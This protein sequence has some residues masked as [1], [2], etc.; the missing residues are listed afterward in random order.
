MELGKHNGSICSRSKFL[1]A[2]FARMTPD[3]LSDFSTTKD[4]RWML[5][6]GERELVFRDKGAGSSKLSL[7]ELLFL[8]IRF[9]ARP[10]SRGQKVTQAHYENS[11]LFLV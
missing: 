11:T 3:G 1:R 8:T 4:V 9:L 7:A 6:S 5:R 2:S 10:A